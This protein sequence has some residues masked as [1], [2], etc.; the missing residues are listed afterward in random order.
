ML[1]KIKT[2]YLHGIE[3]IFHS[4]SSDFQDK[5]ITAF[6]FLKHFLFLKEQSATIN[7]RMIPFNEDEKLLPSVSAVDSLVGDIFWTDESLKSEK[8]M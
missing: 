3:E 5:P 4:R 2:E 8:N 1:N 6:K 7:T